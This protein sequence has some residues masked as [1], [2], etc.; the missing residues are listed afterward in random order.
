MK[1]LTFPCPKTNAVVETGVETDP[2][3]LASIPHT[4]MRIQCPHCGEAHEFSSSEG[5][6]KSPA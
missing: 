5:V 1:P 2:D 6:L 3:T 4:T